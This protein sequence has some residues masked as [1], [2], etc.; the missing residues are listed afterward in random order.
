M[1][2]KRLALAVPVQGA[3]SGRHREELTRITVTEAFILAHRTG[4][5]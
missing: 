2:N 5:P 4:S 1:Q 3:M